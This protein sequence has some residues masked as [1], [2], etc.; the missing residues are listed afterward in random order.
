MQNVILNKLPP[1][2]ICQ[3]TVSQ[4]GHKFIKLGYEEKQTIDKENINQY[5][6]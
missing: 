5:A 6:N 1:M 3:I 4:N 2:F